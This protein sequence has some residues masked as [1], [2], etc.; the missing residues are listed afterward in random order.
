MLGLLL[1][2]VLNFFRRGHVILGGGMNDYLYL[3]TKM[4]NFNLIFFRLNTSL[5]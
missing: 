5:Y 4:K 2:S 3:P 1:E